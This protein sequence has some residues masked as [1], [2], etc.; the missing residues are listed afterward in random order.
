M[1]DAL[2]DS[3]FWWLT[4][5]FLLTTFIFVSFSV[6]LIPCVIERGFS[7]AVAAS[8][9]AGVGFMQI[10]G[11]ILFA[12]LTERLS[13]RIV[14]TGIFLMQSFALSLFLFLPNTAG[15]VAFVMLFGMSAGA[16]T[17]SRAALTAERYGAERYGGIS[18]VQSLTINGIRA[19]APF[20]ISL[21][22]EGTGSYNSFF[23][24][25]IGLSLLGAF[26]ILLHDRKPFV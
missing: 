11:R 13:G 8:A 4:A 3:G 22:R 15:L 1:R 7:P 14:V 17:P 9:L 23:V 16:G 25:G 26:C 24:L 5:A 12:P 10:P 6:H 21:L 19:A 18:G 2:R 20:C